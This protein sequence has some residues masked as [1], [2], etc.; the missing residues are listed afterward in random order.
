MFIISPVPDIKEVLNKYLLS[1]GGEKRK[2]VASESR[3]VE[4]E[5][6]IS[7]IQIFPKKVTLG[8]SCKTKT[9]SPNLNSNASKS[10]P[11]TELS[12]N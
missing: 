1:K 3:N 5:K 10:Y 8:H 6:K 12:S 4:E 2:I 7:G 11:Y 9:S